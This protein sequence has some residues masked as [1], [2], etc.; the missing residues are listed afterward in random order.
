MNLKEV[1][2]VRLLMWVLLYLVTIFVLMFAAVVPAVK[3]YKAIRKEYLAQKRH[4]EEVRERH[5]TVFE[6]LKTVQARHRKVIEAFENRWNEKDFLRRAKG[7]FERLTLQPVETNASEGRYRIYEINAR[8]GMKSPGSFYR[9][10]D[11]LPGMPYVIAAD[12]PIAFRSVG[13]E[14]IEGVFRIK[15]Y[16]ER[17]KKSASSSS[18][19]NA[20][21]R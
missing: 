17:Q 15:V 14:S 16:E 7:Y 4:L 12:F 2:L 11:A 6:R 10:L 5:D 20:S 13:G 21:K 1:R 3:D 19:A 18:D 9:F 8:T